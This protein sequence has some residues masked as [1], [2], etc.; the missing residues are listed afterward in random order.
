[1]PS[2]EIRVRRNYIEKVETVIIKGTDGLV[3]LNSRVVGVHR[4]SKSS[5]LTIHYESGSVFLTF[6]SPEKAEEAYKQIE[7]YLGA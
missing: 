6:D 5:T 4:T 1:M 3:R 2:H 7:K